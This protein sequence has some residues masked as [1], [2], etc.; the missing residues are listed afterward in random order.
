MP[1]SNDSKKP[2]EAKKEP[3][4]E[5]DSEISA[6]K[7]KV[8]DY[9]GK[10]LKEGDFIKLDKVGRTIPTALD[11]RVIVFEATNLEDAKKMPNFDIKNAPLYQ[12]ELVLVGA[13]GFLQENLSK[14]L[15]TMKY[16]EEKWIRLEPADAFG[17]KDIKKIERMSFKK[18]LSVKKERP[19]LGMDFHDEKA[20][21][22]GQVIYA[23][24]GRVRIDYNHPLAGRPIE[25]KLKPL[26][27]IDGFEEKVFAFLGRYMANVVP[28]L[29]KLDYKKKD[30]VLNIEVPQFFAFQQN[31]GMAEL[32][33]SNDLQK[34]L[35]LETV[36]FIHS[37]KKP[38]A[39]PENLEKE[40]EKAAEEITEEKSKEKKVKTKKTSS[41]KKTTKKST[42]KSSKK[43]STKKTTKKD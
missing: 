35:E 34:H 8:N 3:I 39:T 19:R 6:P 15:E 25:Y 43:K 22:H 20:N 40:V 9:M 37:Y 28:D 2:N 12:P 32:R 42:K 24:Q 33:S 29:F 5:K 4:K 27:R 21:R 26:E 16:G 31:L 41:K 7:E 38:P 30:K 36:N 1:E 10:P 17:V 11:S 18:F 14:E 13:E 23:D